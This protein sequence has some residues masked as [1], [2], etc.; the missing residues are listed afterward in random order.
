MS[1]VSSTTTTT[2][3]IVVCSVA[4]VSSVTGKI[5]E[6]MLKLLIKLVFTHKREILTLNFRNC[7]FFHRYRS[8]L[9][10]QWSSALLVCYLP[11]LYNNTLKSF[12]PLFQSI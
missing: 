8:F 6:K 2:S 11:T 5:A 7:S 3:S 12:L 4:F 10:R 1:V 9:I